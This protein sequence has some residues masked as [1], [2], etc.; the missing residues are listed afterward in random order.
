MRFIAE[1]VAFEACVHHVSWHVARAIHGGRSRYRDC[2]ERVLVLTRQRQCHWQDVLDAQ[3]THCFFASVGISHL[4]KDMVAVVVVIIVLYRY[5][6]YDH[7][8]Y[9]YA[10]YICQK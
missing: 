6:N 3:L 9:Y 7:Y 4:E 2:T 8:H 1:C 5:Y 10:D